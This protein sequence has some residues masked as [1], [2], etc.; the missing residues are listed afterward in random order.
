ML[1]GRIPVRKAKQLA[2]E[3]LNEGIEYWH[4]DGY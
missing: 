2:I 4:Y 3:L 1:E